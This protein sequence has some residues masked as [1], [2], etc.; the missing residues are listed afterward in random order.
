LVSG[1]EEFAFCLT[2]REAHLPGGI[3]TYCLFVAIGRTG[4]PP[5]CE[6]DLSIQIV[7]CHHVT[8]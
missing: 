2:E 8:K 1:Q 3:C 6:L 7:V 5:D 4:M